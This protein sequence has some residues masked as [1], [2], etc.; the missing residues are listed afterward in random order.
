V[1]TVNASG[2]L[3]L[4]DDGLDFAGSLFVKSDV[5][6]QTAISQPTL[7]LIAEEKF[8]QQ[9]ATATVFQSPILSL[10]LLQLI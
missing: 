5:P 8:K 9:C 10:P 1:K 4:N 2:Q 7:F 3:A 6:R